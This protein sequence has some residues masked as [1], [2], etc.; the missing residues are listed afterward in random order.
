MNSC[1][2]RGQRDV[3]QTNVVALPSQRGRRKP[4]RFLLVRALSVVYHVLCRNFLVGISLSNFRA[5]SRGKVRARYYIC[6][7]LATGTYVFF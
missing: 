7:N 2:V 4:R 3:A 5:F 1:F 6:R